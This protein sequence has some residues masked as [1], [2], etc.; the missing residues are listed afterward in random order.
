MRHT[1]KLYIALIIMASICFGCGNNTSN[2]S[3]LSNDINKYASMKDGV[4]HLDLNEARKHP[5]EVRFSEICDSIIYIPLETKKECIIGTGGSIEIDEENI[6]INFSHALYLFNIEG[7]FLRQIGRKGRGPG[8]FVC[9]EFCLNKKKK[10]IYAVA[11]YKHIILEFDYSGKLLNENL[12]VKDYPTNMIYCDKTNTI[13][14]THDYNLS[15][16]GRSKAKA[17]YPLL[18][19]RDLKGNI[20][21]SIKSS[22]FPM[23][24]GV[25][26]MKVEV[27]VSGNTLSLY[28]DS[29]IRIQEYA[30]DT[31]YEYRG[32]KLYPQII[33]NNKEYKH[34]FTGENVDR[35]RL[36]GDFRHVK[37][38]RI[39]GESK[40]FVF[41]GDSEFFYYDKEEKILHNMESKDSKNI[42]VNDIDD[43]FMGKIKRIINNEF[44]LSD[45]SADEFIERTEV[46]TM[47][48]GKMY[49]S[50]SIAKGISEESNPVLILYRLRN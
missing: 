3:P 17:Q 23:K 20:L 50:H 48:K 39:I 18:K 15:S 4:L 8:E 46:S 9:T 26:K 6:F 10:R 32:S 35:A 42:L 33:L 40:R 1:L 37:Y 36:T 14:S 25:P 45:V 29:C 38:N 12:S 31:L 28:Q 2:R 41:V 7:K 11:L 24:Y 30:N 16:N 22:Y 34:K 44:I 13:F 43:V 5:K 21:R 27:S 47:N 49:M 19:E